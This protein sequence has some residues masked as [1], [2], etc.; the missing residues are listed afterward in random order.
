ML[1]SHCDAFDL[2][3]TL[4]APNRLLR[5]SRL[6]SQA[7]DA[8]VSEFQA[9]GVEFDVLVVELGAVLHDS[10]KIQH[11]NELYEAGSLHEQAG[12]T[13]LLAHEVQPEI[14][15]CCASH[16]RWH[17]PGVSFEERVVALADKLWKGKRESDLE[18]NIIDEIAARLGQSRW[19]VFG[20]LDTVF[21]EIAS[22]GSEWLLASSSG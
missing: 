21:E 14:A 4:G 9:L 12:Q 7:A 2:L 1:E 3:K 6:V 16:G 11:S 22:R 13:L 20:K 8:L 5:H 18:L 17:L 19:D 15:R 10:G